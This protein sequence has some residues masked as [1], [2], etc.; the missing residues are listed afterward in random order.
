MDLMVTIVEGRDLDMI[1]GGQNF[2]L[3][4]SR[5]EIHCSWTSGAGTSIPGIFGNEKDPHWTT[6]VEMVRPWTIEAGR[7]L[8]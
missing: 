8:I 4:I 1:S 7:H 3:P 2:R 6:G 5:A